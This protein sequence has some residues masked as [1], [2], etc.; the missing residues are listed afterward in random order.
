VS[1]ADC[2]AAAKAVAQASHTVG[3]GATFLAVDLDPGV[4]VSTLNSFLDYVDAKD[5]PTMVDAKGVAA[6]EIPGQRVEQRDRH[7]PGRAGHLPC[8]Q[9]EPGRDRLRG[10]RGDVNGLLTLAFTG[11]LL[12]PVNPCGVALL[13]AYLPHTVADQPDLP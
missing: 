4:P 11:G 10:E 5:L 3:D 2:S 8:R 12:A 9:P 7:R 6:R 13:P 1:C